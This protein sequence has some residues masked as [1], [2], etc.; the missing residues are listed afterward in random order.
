MDFVDRTDFLINL[1]FE[2]Q[3]RPFL[4]LNLVKGFL[5]ELESLVNTTSK[6]LLLGFLF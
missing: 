2:T 6:V 1:I 4:L 5:P 3:T